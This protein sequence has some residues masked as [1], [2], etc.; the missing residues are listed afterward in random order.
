VRSYDSARLVDHDGGPAVQP[1]SLA[2][3]QDGRLYW[4]SAG[5]PRV[6]RLD[7]PPQSAPP[8]SVPAPDPPGATRC[9]PSGARTEAAAGRARIYS[10]E[11]DDGSARFVVC[12]LRTGRRIAIEEIDD[13]E[14]DYSLER[15]RFAGWYVAVAARGCIEVDCGAGRILRVDL[16]TGE[17]RV[18]RGGEAGEVATTSLVLA[19]DGALAYVFGMRPGLT[20]P[21]EVGV[22]GRDGCR[23]AERSGDVGPYSL[24]LDSARRVYWTGGGDLPRSAPLD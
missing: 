19:P 10:I 16:R 3:A 11:L 15:V 23:L 17:V 4:T 2:L 12:N 6:A 1:R 18:I 5:V 22:C 8:D 7:P 13:L 14:E 9:Y 20:G 24:A 21:R